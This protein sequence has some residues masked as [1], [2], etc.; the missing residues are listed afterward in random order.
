MKL[1]NRNILRK[2]LG[3][4]R[5]WS[6]TDRDAVVWSV[7]TGNYYALVKIQGSATTIKAHYPRNWRTTP[8]WLKPGNAVRIRHRSGVQG[9]IELVGHGRDIPTPVEGDILPIPGIS[10][11]GIVSG[12]DVLEYSDGGMN[13]TVSDGIYRIDGTLYVFNVAVTG[14]IVM[15]DPP[16]MT[17]AAPVV[18]GQHDTVTPVVISAAPSAGN[19][20]Y[21][22]LVIGTDGVVDVIEGSVVNLNN[23]PPYPSVPSDHILIGYLFIYGGMT[24]IPQ[25]WIGVKWTTPTPNT[26]SPSS[27]MLQSDGTFQM[28]WNGGD[29]TPWGSIQFNAVDQYGNSKVLSVTATFTL[30]SGTG[31]VGPSSTGPWDT[32]ASKTITSYA[33]FYYHRNQL[34]TPEISPLLQV[35]F[36]NYPSLTYLFPLILLTVGGD[37]V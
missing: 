19:G 4:V 29:D 35:E 10:S 5:R 13:V 32:T 7:D 26:I 1:Y 9:Y 3:A 33:K 15:D 31:E 20:R 23:E 12:M 21:D 8:T 27:T 30:M 6:V 2:R 22:A 18:M 25:N 16:P 14:Y 11:D 28:A 34:A 36:A 24:S 37:P 17:M